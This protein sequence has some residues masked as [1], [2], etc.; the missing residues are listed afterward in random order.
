MRI[1]GNKVRVY[2]GAAYTLR[3]TATITAETGYVGFMAENGVVCDLLRLGDAWYYEPYGNAV[4][5]T[6][7]KELWDVPTAT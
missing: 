1:R 7:S 6:R 3:F 2:S 5:A 4:N